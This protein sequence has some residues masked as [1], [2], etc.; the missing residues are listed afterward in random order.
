MGRYI[1]SSYIFIPVSGRPE[2]R[3][4]CMGRYIGSSY[5]F[6]PVSGKPEAR[7]N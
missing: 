1:G 6:I 5:I 3:K 7:K 2:A 4:N